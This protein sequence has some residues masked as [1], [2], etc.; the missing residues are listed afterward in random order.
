[1]DDSIASLLEKAG[2]GKISRAAAM[3]Q[4]GQDRTDVAAVRARMARYLDVMRDSVR[5]GMNAERRSL[6]G[7][8]GG[9][10]ARL[11]DA[12]A[13]GKTAG[14]KA[15]T[16]MELDELPPDEIVAALKVMKGV[17]SVTLLRAD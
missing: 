6:S 14:G 16:T 11:F 15:M 5:V 1:M 10:A 12:A 2:D 4:A 7:L 8:T 9:Q 13:Q 17:E 3:A